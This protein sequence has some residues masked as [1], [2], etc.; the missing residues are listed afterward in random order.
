MNVASNYRARTPEGEW[1]DRTEWVRVRSSVSGPRP[2][3]APPQG[4]ARLRRRA[5]GSPSVD[6]SRGQRPRRPGADSPVRSSSRAA[7][8]REDGRSPRRAWRTSAPARARRRRRA[9]R[10]PVLI[11][12][13]R[14]RPAAAPCTATRPDL[15]P[16][17]R[18]RGRGLVYVPLPVRAA[19]CRTG[20]RTSRPE[21]LA[22]PR[23]TAP[24]FPPR[25]RRISDMRPATTGEIVAAS[26]G[27][28]GGSRVRDD[29][30]VPRCGV[31]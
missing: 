16:C 12:A 28:P 11:G 13:A 5:P 19:P 2:W 14:E 4:H 22:R 17:R 20:N 27:K 26:T 31:R 6:G 15:A 21:G 23:L 8:G 18:S 10:H 7:P 29:R 24:M 25:V 3:P 30:P 9:R 1:Q